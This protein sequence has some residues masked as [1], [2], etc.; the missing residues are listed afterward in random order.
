MNDRDKAWAYLSRVVEGP[1]AHIYRLLEQGYSVEEI[2]HGVSH[3]SDWIGGLLKE[4]QAR[5]DWRRYEEDLKIISDL[6]GRL[7][8]PD[9]LEW[10]REECEQAFGFAAS[11]VSEHVRSYQADALP[12]HALWVR[13]ADLNTTIVFSVGVVGTRAVSRYG[14]LATRQLV[15]GLVDK[16]VGIISGGA[17]GIDSIAHTQALHRGGRTTVVT[18]CG[19]DRTYPARN[20]DLFEQIVNNGG[21]IISEYPPGTTPQRH[22]FL[23]RNRLV[24]ALSLGTVVVEAAWRSGALNTLSWAAG[25]GRVAMAVPGPITGVSSL[26][27]HERIRRGEAELVCSADEIRALI[28]KIGQV[29][30]DGHYEDEFAANAVQKLSRNELRVY[31]ALPMFNNFGLDASS[32]AKNTGLPLG[33]T[34][35]LL[36]DLENKSIVRRD[37]NQWCR[38]E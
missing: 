7:V 13:G 2:A 38:Q 29:D 20:A 31:D 27:C 10:P 15:Q 28:S 22:R 32:I 37:K 25:F 26:G 6:G 4:T 36:I 21:C 5:W 24:A 34:M 8:T 11:G 35:H 18:A 12:P 16:H 14:K 30:I 3:R 1:S 23:T 33:L 9:S 19:L 17:I